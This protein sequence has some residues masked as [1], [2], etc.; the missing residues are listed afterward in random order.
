MID[1]LV[2]NRAVCVKKDVPFEMILRAGPIGRVPKD[3]VFPKEFRK[4]LLKMER[5]SQKLPKIAKEE[6]APKIPH[7]AWLEKYFGEKKK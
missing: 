7:S 3:Y 6:R 5:A 4:L 2:E 1:A